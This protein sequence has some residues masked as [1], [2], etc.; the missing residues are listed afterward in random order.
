MEKLKQRV[1]LLHFQIQEEIKDAYI[2][3]EKA[4]VKM[5]EVER[6]LE[7]L[8]HQRE[9]TLQTSLASFQT[10]SH[11]SLILQREE[12]EFL[13]SSLSFSQNLASFLL[14]ETVSLSAFFSYHQ[15]VLAR[16]DS[17]LFSSR[18]LPSLPRETFKVEDSPNLNLLRN[19]FSFNEMLSIVS[20][21]FS[22]VEDDLNFDEMCLVNY[23]FRVCVAP[24][25]FA[26]RF[27]DHGN[28]SDFFDISFEPSDHLKVVLFSFQDS[29]WNR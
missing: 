1:S 3:E 4:L 10:S 15:L 28:F 2:K 5:E 12:L 29:P 22:Y 19:T 26:N 13:M 18:I 20:P 6:N 24:F 25:D 16:L 17:L 7:T 21:D 8:L 27:F 14:S 9:G 23:E 11:K